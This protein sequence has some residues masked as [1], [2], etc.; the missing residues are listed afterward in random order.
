MKKN[1]Y[2]RHKLKNRV[3][4]IAIYIPGLIVVMLQLRSIL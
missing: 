3:E 2:Q 1:P 4:L